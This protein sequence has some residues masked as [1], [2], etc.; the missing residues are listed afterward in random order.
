MKIYTDEFYRIVAVNKNDAGTGLK[1]HEVD[2]MLFNGWCDTVIKG[3]CY[4]IN[5]DGSI[6][7]YPYKDFELL[8]SI[9]QIYEEKEKQITELQL[10]LTQVFEVA[11]SANISTMKGEDDTW[12]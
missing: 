1:E 3:Y 2:D 12:T 6:A 5:D 10:A 9:Q 4:Q 11:V 8:M 7:V